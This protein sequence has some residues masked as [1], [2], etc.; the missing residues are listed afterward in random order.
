MLNAIATG[1][2][3][4]ARSY[5]HRELHSGQSEDEARAH[6]RLG[7]KGGARDRRRRGQPPAATPL[8]QSVG[9]SSAGERVTGRSMLGLLLCAGVLCPALAYGA[10]PPGPLP[11]EDFRHYVD[12]LDPGDP[13]TLNSGIPNAEAWA[14]ILS[15]VHPAQA[16]AERVRLAPSLACTGPSVSGSSRVRTAPPGCAC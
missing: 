9:P 12:V 16:E 3:Y 2:R 5:L 13:E 1:G 11:A 8:S 4:R 7:R 6:A 15:G 14:W 10:D